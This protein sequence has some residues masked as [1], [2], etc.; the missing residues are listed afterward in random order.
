MTVWII[1]PFD[2][3]PLEGMR[4]QRY[5]LMAQAFASAGWTVR[6]WSS[7]FNHV[8]KRKRV[9]REGE[10]QAVRVELLPTLPYPTNV[11]WA[12][13][14]SHRAWAEAVSVRAQAVAD[15]GE[16]PDVVVASTPPLGLCAAAMAFARGCG[17]KFVCDIQDAWPETFLRLLPTGFKWTGAVL[18]APLWK[19]ARKLYREADLVTG[20][21]RRYEGLSGRDD[22]YL[23]YHG[24]AGVEKPDAR[25][26]CATTSGVSR[27]VYVGNLGVGYDLETVLRALAERPALTLDIAGKGPREAQLRREAKALR[28]DGRVRFHGYLDEEELRDV[29]A[30]CDV[31][32]IPMRDDSWVGL[33]YKL[34][35]YLKAGLPVVSSLHGECGDLLRRTGYGRTYDWGSSASLLAALDALPPD[36]NVVLPEGLRAERIYPDYV[37]RVSELSQGRI[38]EF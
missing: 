2:N 3:L 26:R 1:N 15:G 25:K 13:I 36:G 20:V 9:V 19:T 35:D 33:P 12:R 4:P 14:R 32:V 37:S 38:S 34:G 8:T 6:L 30:R 18:L 17:A 22:F 5:W 23:A 29:M 21:C 10:P 7:D 31:G 28:L 27:L 16:R 11:C 24:I